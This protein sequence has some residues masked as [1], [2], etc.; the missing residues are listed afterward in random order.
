MRMK[1][2]CGCEKCCSKT[3]W[4][5]LS[6]HRITITRSNGKGGRKA[7]S[8][9]GRGHAGTEI[10]DGAKSWDDIYAMYNSVSWRL[11]EA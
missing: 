7:G 2:N 4:G 11:E 1:I 6:P 8:F 10:I 9:I 3:E 5:G